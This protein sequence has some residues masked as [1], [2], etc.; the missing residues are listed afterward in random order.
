MGNALNHASHNGLFADTLNLGINLKSL[1]T[2]LLVQVSSW[3]NH[4]FHS[5]LITTSLSAVLICFAGRHRCIGESFAYVQ[6]KTIWSVLL[7]KYEFDL[8]DGY[9]PPVNYSTMVHTPTR[10]VIQY[11]R[12]KNN[13]EST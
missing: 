5:T 10:P 13:R 11:R 7:R 2:Y 8:C 3:S 9:F 12:R 6:M 1:L 4:H